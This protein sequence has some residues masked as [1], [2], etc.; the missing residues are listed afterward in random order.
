MS[1]I[2]MLF[3]YYITLLLFVNNLSIVFQAYQIHYGSL[4]TILSW[5]GISI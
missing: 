4:G 1:M 3:A 5:F 2:I